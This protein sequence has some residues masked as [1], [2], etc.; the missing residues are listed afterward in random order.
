MSV[1]HVI[2]RMYG[3]ELAIIRYLLDNPDGK[4]SMQISKDVKISYPNTL[5]HVKSLRS[6]GAIKKHKLGRSII[7]YVKNTT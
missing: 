3:A 1:Y 5:T 2:K 4:S 6:K 7:Y